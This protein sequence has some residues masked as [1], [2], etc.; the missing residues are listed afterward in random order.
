MNCPGGD[1][2]IVFICC[3]GLDNKVT[4]YPLHQE[5]EV[6]IR[7]KTVATHTSYMSC[8]VF[9]NSDQQILTGSGDSSCALWDVESGQLLQSFIGHSSDVMSVD[10]APS[11]T[12][13][14]FVSG[15]CDKLVFIWDMRTGQC[16][17]SFEG[18]Q[19][20]VNSVRNSSLQH[21]SYWKYIGTIR[22]KRF[23]I[24]RVMWN[25]GKISSRR[26]C[27]SYGFRRRHLSPL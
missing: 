1:L 19:S 9:P 11:E 4:V 6:S 8:C 15:S 17:Q 27:S 26:R 14:T 21:V 22:G 18:H 7:K 20:D 2:N 5:D 24:C 3:R 23:A 12:G 16:V 10:L 25:L 13:N